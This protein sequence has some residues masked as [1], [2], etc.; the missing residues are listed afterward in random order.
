MSNVNKDALR[1]ISNAFVQLKEAAKTK[2]NCGASYSVWYKMMLWDTES[3]VEIELLR[4][5][6]FNQVKEQVQR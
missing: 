6:I 2:I 3:C 4:E 1:D 5:G